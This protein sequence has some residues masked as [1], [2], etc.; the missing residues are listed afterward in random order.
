L[1]LRRLT[2]LIVAFACFSPLRPAF[3][4]P[5]NAAPA[6]APAPAP[7]RPAPQPPPPPSDEAVLGQDQQTIERL[8]N[9]AGTAVRETQLKTIQQQIAPVE[10]QANQVLHKAMVQDQAIRADLRKLRRHARGRRPTVADQAQITALIAQ[11]TS[12]EALAQQAQSVASAA[13]GVYGKIA[14]ARRESFSSRFLV[15]AQSPLF[16]VFWSALAGSI[17]PDIGR[18]AEFLDRAQ[19]A[20]L[21]ADEPKGLIGLLA[22][23]TVLFIFAFPAR[24]F[25]ERQG[26]RKSG[27]SVH[28]GFARTAAALWV[29]VVDI[30]LPTLGVLAFRLGAQWGGLLSDGADVMGGAA[31]LA[32]AWACATVAL[33]RV[34]STDP[35]PSQHLL[36]ISAEMGRRVRGP[37]LALA[38]VTA[39]GLLLNRLNFAIGASVAATIATDCLIA[40]AYVVVAGFILISVGRGRDDGAEPTPLWTLVSLGLAAAMV[41][42]VGAILAG[43]TTLAGL[44]SGQI[45]WLSMIAAGAYLLLRF[46]DEACGASFGPRG[47]AA[48]ILRGLFNLRRSIIQQLGVLLS[49]GLELLLLIAAL[50]LALTPFGQGGAGL[51]GRFGSFDQTIR[52][53]SV[54]LSPNALAAGFVTL[55][56]G[57]LM[58][59][60]ARAWM[61]R[62]YLPVTEWDSGLRNS[63]TT[64]VVYL[65]AC[66]AVICALAAMGLGFQQIALVASALSVGIGFGLQQ[67]VQNFVSG[68]IVLIERPIK[69]GDW[70]NVDGVDGDVRRIRVRATEIQTFDR[71]TVIVPNSDLITK[72][73]TSRTHG[74]RAARIHLQISIASPDDAEKAQALI[75]EIAGA[76]PKVLKEPQ[77][78]VLIN[79]LA[80][81]GAV[82]FDVYLY[83]ESARDG[84]RAKSEVYFEV[85]RRFKSE[86]VDFLGAAGPATTIMEVGPD[87]RALLEAAMQAKPPKKGGQGAAG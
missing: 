21:A 7:P 14:Q 1:N 36:P 53:G 8:Q 76:N 56:V 79:S 32:V 25:L 67:I 2:L 13:N 80:A 49:A 65:G 37:V 5:L 68:V 59:R 48:R 3:G 73:V 78:L 23:M 30:S 38:L 24:R 41:T 17:E 39:A 18:L 15:R 60:G 45:F 20:A 81:A 28:P 61:V 54:T 19:D 33:G 11:Q 27:E 42:T 83:V 66:V 6:S 77:P 75:L 47:W 22:G 51:F 82:N 16:P 46:V 26:R 58:V 35:D 29:V 43:Y 63:V 70:I 87:S 71:A 52:I 9:Q 72:L 74:E 40:L 57:M 84:L 62:R 12:V 86:T 10:A 85:L 50:R 31:V 69:V 34:L 44:V 4:D 55:A 64:G